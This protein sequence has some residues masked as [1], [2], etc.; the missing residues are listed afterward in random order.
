MIAVFNRSYYEDVLV[1]FVGKELSREDLVQRCRLINDL[2]KN[3]ESGGVRVLKFF[4]NVSHGEQQKRIRERLTQPHKRWKYDR[5]DQVA[6]DKYDDY[7]EAYEMIFA[8][9]KV[10]EWHIIP[11][12]RRWYRNY[13]VAGILTEHL[14]ALPLQFPEAR[15]N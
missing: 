9:C 10:A 13:T 12:D 1:P 6:A 15:K 5:E 11:A 14:E 3:L 4:L 8:E 2:E 7:M